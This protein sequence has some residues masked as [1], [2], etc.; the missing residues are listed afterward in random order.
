MT[1]A[2]ESSVDWLRMMH[3]YS[4]LTDCKPR[5]A[6]IADE[7]ER[8]RLALETIRDASL[9]DQP[10]SAAGDDRAWAMQ[11]IAMLR[12]LAKGALT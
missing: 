8:L 12:G 2:K 9:P 10:A 5:F 3:D 6:S 4:G 11:H 1:R 7:I